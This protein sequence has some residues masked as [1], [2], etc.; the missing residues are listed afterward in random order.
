MTSSVSRA[1]PIPDAGLGAIVYAL[2]ILAGAGGDRRWWRTTPWLVLL[3]GLL[4]LPMGAVSAGFIIIQPTVIGALCTLCLIQAAVTVLLIPYA[5]DEIAATAQFL[6][7]S[8]QAGRPF[9]RTL[10]MGGP[11]IGEREQRD[12]S[13]KLDLPCVDF[14]RE[15]LSGGVSY[16]WTL[17]ASVIVGMALMATGP[18]LGRGTPLVYS[19]HI[20][21]CL[22]I[23][24]A[25]TAMA[26]VARPVRFLNV[27]LGA[28]LVASPFV[29]GRAGM[30]AMAGDVVLGVLLA[31]LSLPRGERSEEHYGGWDR[32]VV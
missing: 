2:D 32:Y 6:R 22:V 7:R 31:L 29:L 21:G 8:H 30:L 14:V 12:P 26:E 10:F 18:L 5:I 9:W 1:F 24:V 27:A 20:V 28:W 4:I 15:F 23:L 13:R 17:V 16:P 19:D 11:P 3:F 25:V